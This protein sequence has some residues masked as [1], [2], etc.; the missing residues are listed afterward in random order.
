MVG[1]GKVSVKLEVFL[2]HSEFIPCPSL[3]TPVFLGADFCNRFVK[4]IRPRKKLIGRD[5]GST[6][7]IVTHPMK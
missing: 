3:A 4:A 5:D 2:I 1:K 6:V 7:P